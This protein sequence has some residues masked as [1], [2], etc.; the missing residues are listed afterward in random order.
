MTYCLDVIETRFTKACY[1]WSEC[2]LT[3][4]SY[5]IY[6]LTVSES[7]IAVPVRSMLESEGRERSRWLEPTKHLVLHGLT[8]PGS[9]LVSQGFHL[10]ASPLYSLTAD[11]DQFL[12]SLEVM[13]HTDNTEAH[14]HGP[15]I[16]AISMS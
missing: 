13:T 15:A 6:V 5:P 1:V 14:F 12:S 8:G 11:L 2:E 4:Q 9:H 7:G 3:V 16:K 10:R